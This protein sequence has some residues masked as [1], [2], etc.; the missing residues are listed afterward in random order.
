LKRYAVKLY[1][2]TMNI[3]QAQVGLIAPITV[4]DSPAA[5]GEVDWQE[6]SDNGKSSGTDTR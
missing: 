6:G 2:L 4:G 1:A 3:L 5:V